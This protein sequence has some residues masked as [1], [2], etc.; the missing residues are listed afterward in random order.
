MKSLEKTLEEA[1]PEEMITVIVSFSNIPPREEE[2]PKPNEFEN[3]T[4]WRQALI[5]L[6]TQFLRPHIEPKLSMLRET[7]MTIKSPYPLSTTV[8]R[9]TSSQIREAL[10]ISGV[11]ILPDQ[12]FSLF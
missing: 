1:S 10:K 12:K 4:A 3:R 8:G 11:T 5:D 2:A 9:G 6:Q 7:G